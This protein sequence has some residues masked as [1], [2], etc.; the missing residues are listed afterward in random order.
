MSS[1]TVDWLKKISK[2]SEVKLS[3]DNEEEDETETTSKFDGKIFSN[4]KANVIKKNYTSKD[5][6]GLQVAHDLDSFV[7]GQSDILVLEDR[8]VLEDVEESL[9]SVAL[10]EEARLKRMREVSRH[11]KG[12]SGYR[13]FEEETEDSVV[14]LGFGVNSRKI[15][16]KYD[17]ASTEFNDEPG[18]NEGGFKIGALPVERK[19]E[20]EQTRMFNEFDTVESSGIDTLNIL[21]KKR[22]GSEVEKEMKRAKKLAKT[23][24]ADEPEMIVDSMNETENVFNGED[25]DDDSDMQRIISATRRENLKTREEFV[26]REEETFSGGK[27]F[28]SLMMSESI[29]S[30]RDPEVQEEQG[31]ENEIETE[32][33]DEVPTLKMDKIPDVPSFDE[34]AFSAE[35]LVRDGVAST[36]ALLNMR[37]INLKA[38]GTSGTNLSPSSEIKLEYFDQFGNK[39]TSK[40]AYKELS[41]KFHGKAAGKD[42]VEKMKRKRAETLKME[43]A[44]TTSQST[45]VTNLRKQQEETGAP[46]MVLST[47][48]QQQFESTSTAA[49]AVDVKKPKIFGLQLKK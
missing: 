13:E 49:V 22:T 4:P 14:T 46:Y 27:S 3:F 16:Q 47:T 9:V 15:L 12:Y 37:G 48:R 42:K 11:A 10:K 6:T 38:R 24:F 23:F 20:S 31:I 2:N 34:E 36:L 45:I 30:P 41:R 39:L 44:V 28:D 32:D 19:S 17:F 40:E 21:K 1:E 43:S 7:A 8:N 5:L 35:P 25:D 33:Q 29:F 18:L 26:N